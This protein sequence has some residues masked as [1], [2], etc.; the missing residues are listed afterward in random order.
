MSFPVDNSNSDVQNLPQPLS[1]L[2][3][4]FPKLYQHD[5]FCKDIFLDLIFAIAILRSILSDAILGTV[6]LE[7]AEIVNTSLI[8][9]GYHKLFTDVIFRIPLIDGDQSIYLVIDFKSDND[10]GASFQML[11]YTYNVWHK[12]WN[13]AG[14][15]E[16]FLLPCVVSLVFHCGKSKFT[17]CTNVSEL[18]D[19]PKDSVLRNF[20]ISYDSLLYDLNAMLENELPQLPLAN[21]FCRTLLMAHNKEVNAKA[22]D[23][24]FMFKDRL[25]NDKVLLRMWDKC[26]YYL[27]T[28]A[29]YFTFDAYQQLVKLTKELGDKIMSPTA[30]ETYYNQAMTIGEAKGKAEGEAKGKAEGEARGKAKGKALSVIRALTRRIEEPSMEVKDKIMSVQSESK[31]DELFDFAL[32]CVSIGEFETALN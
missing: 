14:Q 21:M 15:P 5:Q 6:D 26:L 10:N 19:L 12:D 2:L 9:E 3:Q 22:R 23:L 4:L 24:F 17:A 11:R 20:V 16:N 32:T 8:D 30:A 18:V 31:L 29:K 27:F 28:S 25:I 1:S 7:R 13:D